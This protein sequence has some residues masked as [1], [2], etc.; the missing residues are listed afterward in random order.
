MLMQCNPFFLKRHAFAV[1][2]SIVLF[3]FV[4]GSSWRLRN[5]F[6]TVFSRTVLK[7]Y[8]GAIYVWEVC[9][10]TSLKELPSIACVM[11]AEH[12][13]SDIYVEGV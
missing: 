7:K 3:F 5:V 1:T 9:L 10:T 8:V 4:V 11:F 2:L 12:S 13:T 6:K